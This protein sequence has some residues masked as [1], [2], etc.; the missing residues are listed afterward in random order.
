MVP[1][2]HLCVCVGGGKPWAVCWCTCMTLA[3][4]LLARATDMD[5]TIDSHLAGPSG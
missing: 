2:M 1:L 3:S 5:A 4:T